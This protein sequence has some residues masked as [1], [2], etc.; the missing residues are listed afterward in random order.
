EHLDVTITFDSVEVFCG[1][2]NQTHG[3]A[4]NVDTFRGLHANQYITQVV[5]SIAMYHASDMPEY[6]KVADN[7][8]YKAVQDY[9]YS[10]GGVA[11]ARNPANAECFTY[12]PGTLY[13]NGF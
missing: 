12:Q 7:F 13:E 2:D 1:N 10:I 4:K 6:Y 11:G 5:G 9:M 8:W 3:L